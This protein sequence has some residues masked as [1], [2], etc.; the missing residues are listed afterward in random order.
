[1]FR[2]KGIEGMLLN[3]ALHKQH[4]A[5]YKWDKDTIWGVVEEQPR[6]EQGENGG[7]DPH[8]AG[9]VGP[10]SKRPDEAFARK[11]LDL[12]EYGTEGRIFTY[13]I[14]L[15]GQWRFTVGS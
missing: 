5:I 6:I 7:E 4:N 2:A 8:S 3:R 10:D 9:K 11:F 14:M 13:V 12:V 15:D 1:M